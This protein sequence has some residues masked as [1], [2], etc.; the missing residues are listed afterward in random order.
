MNYEGCGGR[1]CTLLYSWPG[2]PLHYGATGPCKGANAYDAQTSSK[3]LG[4][5]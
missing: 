5:M 4:G 3:G 1:D 2:G